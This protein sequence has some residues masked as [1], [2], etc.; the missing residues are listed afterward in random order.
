MTTVALSSGGI[1]TLWE[2]SVTEPGYR[3]M[4]ARVTA[5]GYDAKCQYPGNEAKARAEASFPR[6]KA[7]LYPWRALA[8]GAGSLPNDAGFVVKSPGRE[9]PPVRQ[10]PESPG[11]RP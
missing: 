3:R 10:G 1:E 6:I 9:V 7:V 2:K 4:C 5:N 8:F 11:N